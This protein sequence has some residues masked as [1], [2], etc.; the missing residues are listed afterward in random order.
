MTEPTLDT[1]QAGRLSGGIAALMSSNVIGAVLAFVLS[2]LI[3]RAAGET[4]LGIYA[5]SVTW[6]FPLALL[7]DAGVGTL[8]SRDLADPRAPSSRAYLRAALIARFV[9]GLPVMVLLIV[10][11]PLLA[12]S[13]DVA[14]GIAISAPLVILT[15]LVGAF[16]AVFRANR[17]MRPAAMLNVGMLLSQVVLTIIVF[18]A[19]SGVVGALWV[20]V[21]TTAGQFAAAFL[22]WRGQ[23]AETSDDGRTVDVRELLRRAFPFAVAAVLAAVQMRV[24]VVLLERSISPAAAGVYTAAARFVEAGR[25]VPQAVFDAMLPFLVMLVAREPARFL[26]LFNMARRG[27]II[28][29]VV[30]GLF[31]LLAAPLFIGLFFGAQFEPSVE[32]LRILGWSLLPMSLK[33]LRGLYWYA[34]K[35]EAWVNT[36]SLFALIGQIIASLVILPAHG[37][38][39]AAWVMLVS[40]AIAAAVLWFVDPRQHPQ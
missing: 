7:V 19:G 24:S 6:V 35:R 20:N 10:A 18:A 16:T 2:V 11:A 38:V 34:Y 21:L 17:R 37:A 13:P 14:T 5:A 29:G 36:V 30:I 9:I 22:I 26:S 3:G 32:V 31:L 1:P 28:Y 33:Y 15:P 27:L 25:L 40:E 12:G 4:G 23:F 8:I 39:G